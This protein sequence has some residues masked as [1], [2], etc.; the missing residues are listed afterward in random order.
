MENETENKIND[1]INLS[2]LII[3]KIDESKEQKSSLEAKA[4]VYLTVV[5]LLLTLVSTSSTS[6]LKFRCILMFFGF[7]ILILCAAIFFPK[8]VSFFK[9]DMLWK[10]YINEVN[11]DDETIVEA[12]KMIV[13]GNE[14][15]LSIMDFFNK[16]VS[17]L[18]M[19]F[20][21]CV[22]V[23]FAFSFSGV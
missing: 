1:N 18:L 22:V 21:V 4:G 19:L 12:A 15:S 20:I 10:M 11:Y 6:Y 16:L 5:S 2:E 23:F 3:H 7:A 14:K 8:D 17:K 9:I 13:E